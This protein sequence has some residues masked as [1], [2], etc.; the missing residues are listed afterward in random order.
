MTL[1]RSQQT[2]KSSWNEHQHDETWCLW[3]SRA[4]WLC[5]FQTQ[6]SKQ[7]AGLQ[8]NAYGCHALGNHSLGDWHSWRRTSRRRS[9]YH[10][11][12][13]LD[14]LLL[15]TCWSIHRRRKWE[16][17]RLRSRTYV[18]IIMRWKLMSLILGMCCIAIRRS[19]SKQEPS[20]KRSVISSI[21]RRSWTL[22]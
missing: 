20:T 9:W 18:A 13:I 3:L 12:L 2:L 1:C 11:Y 19:S 6:W 4:R 16:R 8:T 15:K 22:L 7:N 14:R 10:C 5:I 21:G 17:G